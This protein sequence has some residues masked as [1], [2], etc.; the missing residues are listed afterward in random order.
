[1]SNQ[2]GSGSERHI[3]ELYMLADEVAEVAKCFNMA[4]KAAAVAGTYA[5]DPSIAGKWLGNAYQE[6]DWAHESLSSARLMAGVIGYDE[7][8]IPCPL[9]QCWLPLKFH[10]VFGGRQSEH[11]DNTVRTAT[12]LIL[13]TVPMK[14]ELEDAARYMVSTANAEFGREV[15]Q[16]AKRPH[17]RRER[18]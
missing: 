7:P 8:I 12:G 3:R 4:R 2:D 17:L 5:N 14:R 16:I 6:Y 18:A 1:M 11:H 15:S 10:F 9:P 13:W